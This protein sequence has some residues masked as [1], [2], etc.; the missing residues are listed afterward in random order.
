MRLM[1]L[2]AAF[3]LGGCATA[4]STQEERHAAVCIRDT[5]KQ[6]PHIIFADIIESAH[7]VMVVRFA[8]RY[9]GGKVER[10]VII[11]EKDKPNAPSLTYDNSLGYFPA[12]FGI[13][14]T[15]E[16]RCP[17]VRNWTPET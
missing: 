9:E 8:V 4:P 16:L 2:I 5:L 10:S 11:I 7:N 12:D 17:T 6:S 14:K 3:I 13:E 1:I 15:L